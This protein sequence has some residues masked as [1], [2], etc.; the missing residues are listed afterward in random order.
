MTVI[1]H[2]KNQW[3]QDTG[4]DTGAQEMNLSES[5]KDPLTESYSTESSIIYWFHLSHLNHIWSR[6][7]TGRILCMSSILGNRR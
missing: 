4:P 5:L 7:Q 1:F 6:D 2:H 3:Q